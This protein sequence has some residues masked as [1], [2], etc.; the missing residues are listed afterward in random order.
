MIRPCSSRD[1][2]EIHAIINAAAQVYEKVIPNHC[3]KL[4]YMP[5]VALRRELASGIQFVTFQ[6]EFG[7]LQGIVGLQEKDEL[8]L[9]RHVYT[10]PSYQKTGIASQL[11]QHQCANTK[12]PIYTATWRNADWAVRLYQKLGFQI[13]SDVAEAESLLSAQWPYSAEQAEHF[14]VL[15]FSS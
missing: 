11:I 3:W 8:A 1:F 10:R 4:P 7:E 15:K 12:K 9:I 14:C 13:V 5:A 2:A 6:E